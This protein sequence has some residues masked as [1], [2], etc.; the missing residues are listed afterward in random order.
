MKTWA[1]INQKGGVGKT[2]TAVSLAGHLCGNDKRLLLVDL[3]PHGSLTSY[4][5]YDPDQ[6][7]TGLYSLFSKP[8]TN[9]SEI[10]KMLLPTPIKNTYLL[11]AS[12][13]LA[14]LDRQMGTG[15]GKGLIVSQAIQAVANKFQFGFI[16]CPPMLGIL[17]INALA[18][19]DQLLIP[20]QTDY[21]S[22]NGLDRMI[23]TLDMVEK[24]QH[25]KTPYLIIPTMYD[26][27]TKASLS[28][29]EAMR[30]Q[31]RFQVWG[32]TI[33]IDT[34]FRDASKAGVPLSELAFNSRGSQ[35]YLKL[36]NFL[37]G[38]DDRSKNSGRSSD[39]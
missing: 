7:E 5:G 36:L 27:R 6:M 37:I 25:R 31:Y 2:T 22:L 35:A 14:T 26:Q 18:A 11:A 16:D 30:D 33:P 39:E 21:L 15:M 19:C 9:P 1:V 17:M 34:K 4:L 23:H 20:A 28:A 32:S 24:S 12:S 29:L 38:V 13:A 3:D 10:A 8:T